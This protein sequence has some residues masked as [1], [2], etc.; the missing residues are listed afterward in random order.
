MT[1]VYIGFEKTRNEEVLWNGF[2]GKIEPD[3]FSC[4]FWLMSPETPET[5]V[6]T[7]VLCQ[8]SHF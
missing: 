2:G 6:S 8:K 5:H 1:L 7:Y 3:Y 4:F